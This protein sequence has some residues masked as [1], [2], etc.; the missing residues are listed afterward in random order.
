MAK[1]IVF[2][3]LADMHENGLART[4]VR[5]LRR[6]YPGYSFIYE[7]FAGQNQCHQIDLFGLLNR[8]PNPRS[9]V[10]P[11]PMN[12]L[13]PHMW[14]LPDTARER[15]AISLLCAQADK[16]MLGV[17]GSY[18][19]T[20]QGFAGLGWERGS[21]VVGN[22]NQFA[23]LIAS[24]LLPRRHYKVALIVCFGARSQNYRVD[25]DGVLSEDDIKSSFAYKFF[26]RLCAR[27]SVTLTARTGSVGFNS[28]TGRSEV[29]TEA[30]VNAE[31]DLAE[32]QAA[33]QTARA[34][35]DFE[36][37]Q[38]FMCQSPEGRL[39]LREMIRHMDTPH[40]Q[41]RNHPER[42]IQAYNT[43]KAT[44]TRL[45]TDSNRMVSKY[46]K[47]VYTYDAGTRTATVCRKYENGAKVMR[48][49]Y[50]GAL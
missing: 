19:D 46:G 33:G 9:G 32:L 49:L 34:A 27:V 45:T 37:L 1:T 8:D 47:F 5:A 43:V 23:E 4:S 16:I 29:Q 44:V 36:Q 10:A 41:P 40:A 11:I 12:M 2:F 42:I 18:D 22:V 21:G 25:H 20:D 6:K 7:L 38:Q 39:K 30:A 13:T 35:R 14:C 24:F 26:K 48:V 28:D 3:N 50:Q 31:I 15:F 17:H